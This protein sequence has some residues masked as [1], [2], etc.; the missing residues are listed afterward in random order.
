M[1]YV[2][3]E[4]GQIV[5]SSRPVRMRTWSE[6]VERKARRAFPTSPRSGLTHR[7]SIAEAANGSSIWANGDWQPLEDTPNY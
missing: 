2:V 1:T 3:H 6:H 4:D 5:F 7:S